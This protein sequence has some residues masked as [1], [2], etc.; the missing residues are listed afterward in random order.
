LVQCSP[1]L[2]KTKIDKDILIIHGRDDKVIP[3]E[4]SVRLHHLIPKSQLHS[5]GE[6]GHW[7]QIE[8]NTRFNKLLLNFFQEN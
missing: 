8:H 2:D 6:C 1:N 5:F 4:N 7:S 3:F